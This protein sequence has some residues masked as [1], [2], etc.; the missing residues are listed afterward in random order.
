MEREY[1]F[2]HFWHVIHGCLSLRVD[3][4]TDILWRPVQVVPRLLPRDSWYRLQHPR[5]PDGVSGNRHYSH[6]HRY[7][8]G[9]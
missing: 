4:V 6:R 1:T 8:Q 5:N 9:V 3:P 7:I 2:I